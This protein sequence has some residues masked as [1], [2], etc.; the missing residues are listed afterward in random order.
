MRG[1]E[2]TLR[3][4]LTPPSGKPLIHF[5]HGNGF[6]G[7]VYEPM[8]RRLAEDFDLWLSDVAGHGDSDPGTRFPG[9]NHSARLA[10]E[11]F[12]AHRQ[13]FG[14][15][16]L[17]AVGHSFGGV[18]TTLLLA[19]AEQPFQRAVLLDPVLFSRGMA[20]SMALVNLLRMGRF[21]PLARATLRRR[22]H[23]PSR[24]AALQSL[25][26][27][28]AYRGWSDDALVAFVEH[29]LRDSTDGGVELKCHPE[30]EARVF[31]SGPRGLWRSIARIQVPTLI[32]HGTHTIPFVG[33]AAHRAAGL[34]AQIQIRQVAGGHCFMQEDPESAAA[35]V[36]DFLLDHES[37]PAECSA[38]GSID[39]AVRGTVNPSAAAG[40]QNSTAPE[41]ARK[42]WTT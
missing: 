20:A 33:P 26:G 31:S 19:Q 39:I 37:T 4:W 16:P 23:W 30:T 35:L 6:C 5:L 34:N 21:V 10:L 36:R 41:C 13:A 22:R 12:A 17:F 14:A 40:R 25:Q 7:R 29:A 24:A 42:I 11:A 2:L 9:W 18:L 32:A 3:G 8:L 15:V 28:G 27:R 1:P 38:S